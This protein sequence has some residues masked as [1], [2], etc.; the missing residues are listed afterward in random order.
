MLDVMH[1]I[2]GTDCPRARAIVSHFVG[3][4]AISWQRLVPKANVS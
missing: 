2:S 3:P 1:E 4:A